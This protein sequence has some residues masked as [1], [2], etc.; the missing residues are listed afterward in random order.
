MF[1]NI[2]TTQRDCDGNHTSTLKV[3]PNPGEVPFEFKARL[4]GREM[5]IHS[6]EYGIEILGSDDLFE[7][8][9]TFTFGY[10]REEGYF[11]KRIDFYL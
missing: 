6:D 5:A 11:Q 1:A 3:S 2:T 4:I 10:P 8:S 7:G 9:G